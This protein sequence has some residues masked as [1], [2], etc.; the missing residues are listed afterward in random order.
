MVGLEALAMAAFMV[1]SFGMF[2]M[3]LFADQ[4]TVPSW[5]TFIVLAYGWAVASGGRQAIT[6]YV[7]LSGATRV[8]P[9]KVGIFHDFRDFALIGAGQEFRTEG[10]S[11]R[12][13]R[14]D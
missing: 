4:F 6:T 12:S 8:N 9:V 10:A 3:S 2:V 5:Q 7:L 14:N 13:E 1:S 11:P